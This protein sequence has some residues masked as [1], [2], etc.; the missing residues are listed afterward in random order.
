LEADQEETHRGD[1]VLETLRR[2]LEAARY[3]AD[4]AFRQYDAADPANRLVIAELGLR[5]NRA[6]ESV[7]ELEGRTEVCAS[8]A[9]ANM[10]TSPE[11]FAMLAADPKAIWR[12][13]A[14]DVRLKKRIVRELIREAI[15]D[16]DEQGGEIV[17][18]VH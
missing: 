13:P 2:D 5:W 10:P 7:T 12:D 18:V 16:L 11:R 17:F 8:E 14:T 3:A 4:K 9:P 1:K 6:L 15:A